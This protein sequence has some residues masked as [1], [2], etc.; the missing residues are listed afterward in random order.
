MFEMFDE[1]LQGQSPEILVEKA[2]AEIRALLQSDKAR[3][4]V[5]EADSAGDHDKAPNKIDEE[6]IKKIIEAVSQFSLL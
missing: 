1:V 2:H 3:S 4:L 5:F 6:F